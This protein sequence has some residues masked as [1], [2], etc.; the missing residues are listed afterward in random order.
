MLKE[1]AKHAEQGRPNAVVPFL[2]VSQNLNRKSVRKES[3]D[4]ENTT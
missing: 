1:S 2:N 4:L 3:Y